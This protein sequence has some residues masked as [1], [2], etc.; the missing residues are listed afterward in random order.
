MFPYQEP[1]E[2]GPPLKNHPRKWIT[3][4]AGS[5]GELLFLLVRDQGT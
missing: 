3:F 4:G 5:P 2:R 1:E